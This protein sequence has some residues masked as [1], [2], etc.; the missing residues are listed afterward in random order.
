MA[1]VRAF[2]AL[3]YDRA[4]VGDLGRVLAPPYDVIDPAQRAELAA[5]HP[6]NAVRLILPEGEPDRYT[7]AARL[8]R[9]WV[10][11]GALVRE[12]EPAV[13]V[14]AH[15]FALEGGPAGAERR[16]RA[17]VWAAVRLVELDRGVVLPHERTLA[18]P[19]ADRLALLRACRVQLSPV[20]FVAEDPEGRLA[21]LVGEATRE[22][23]HATAEF[24]EREWHS[25]WRQGGRFAERW[26]RLLS[27]SRLLIADGHHRY[28][29]ALAFRDE[30]RA[31]GGALPGADFVLG[32]IVSERDPG[33]VLRPTHRTLSG[34]A[35][36]DAA[37]ALE[38]A[39]AWFEVADLAA[40]DAAPALAALEAS[41][42]SG[43]AA[44]A[45]WLRGRARPVRLTLRP[46]AEAELPATLRGAAVST[47]HDVLLPR[48]FGLDAESQRRGGHLAYTRDA[49]DAVRRVQANEAQA[50]FLLAPPTFEQLRAAATAGERFP[51]KTTYFTP[52][53]PTG[54]AFRPVDD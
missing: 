50:A 5:R 47:L 1:E 16:V 28:E 12:R 36:F 32:Y 14:H 41:T 52:K 17:G 26:G 3:V 43:R 42:A 25:V 9:S 11:S 30:A 23:A 51:Q 27:G 33:L 18:A 40:D 34:L 53:V 10:D 29:T 7:A 24:P 21:A 2:R 45:A 19:K 38:R 13:W 6:H 31:S 8:L 35:D 15:E 4:R 37:R 39:A 48:V 44:F 20:F 54:I 49:A 46:E 22:P